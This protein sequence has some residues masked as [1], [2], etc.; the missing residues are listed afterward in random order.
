MFAQLASDTGV[1]IATLAELLGT[2]VAALDQADAE[3]RDAGT[4]F[5]SEA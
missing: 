2:S 5:R 4:R 1:T 3:L